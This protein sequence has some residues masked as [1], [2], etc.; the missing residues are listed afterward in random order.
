M[1]GDNLMDYIHWMHNIMYFYTLFLFFSYNVFGMPYK[2]W[3]TFLAIYAPI[4]S[5]AMCFFFAPCLCVFLFRIY[6][7]YDDDLFTLH[8]GLLCLWVSSC[9]S[10]RFT[11][12]YIFSVFCSRYCC[13]FHRVW[14]HRFCCCC[15]H[16]FFYLVVFFFLFCLIQQELRG[17]FVLK[18]VFMHLFFSISPT[19]VTTFS[20]ENIHIGKRLWQSYFTHI[21]IIT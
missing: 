16:T 21:F 3:I 2:H 12:I 11:N 18:L 14:I 15:T 1:C 5:F 6:S 8:I 7:W 4:L 9:S 10:F 13:S 19:L 17:C 20:I